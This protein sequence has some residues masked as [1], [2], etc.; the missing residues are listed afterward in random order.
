MQNLSEILLFFYN[1]LFF[2]LIVLEGTALKKYACLLQIPE[3][4][5]SH[6]HKVV[7]Y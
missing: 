1:K 6:L 3:A 2:Y 7:F 5:K 4:Q